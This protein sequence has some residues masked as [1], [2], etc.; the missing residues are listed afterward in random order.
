MDIQL[1]PDEQEQIDSV[2]LSFIERSE[3]QG[4]ELQQL[5]FDA[6]QI[7]GNTE[8]RWNKQKEMG[9]IKRFWHKVSGGASRDNA[10]NTDD[11]I[12]VQKFAF[13]FLQILQERQLMLAH[14]MLAVKNNLAELA[15]EQKE[16]KAAI[17]EMAK[18]ISRRFNQLEQ[19][20]E[21][22]EISDSIQTWL[23]TIEEE[24]YLLDFPPR[25]R[26]LTVLKQFYT[27]KN[28][29]WNMGELKMFRSALRRVK[30]DHKETIKLSVFVSE[31]IEELQKKELLECYNDLLYLTDEQDQEIGM[32][33]LM[34]NVSIPGLLALKQLPESFERLQPAIEVLQENLEIE[35]IQAMCKVVDKDIRRTFF[36]DL[37]QQVGLFEL[38]VQ[39]LSGFA[40]SRE[41]SSDMT[42][43]TSMDDPAGTAENSLSKEDEKLLSE[44]LEENDFIDIH[45][46]NDEG[47]SYPLRAAIFEEDCSMARL[48]LK[49]GADPNAAEFEGIEMPPL[50]MILPVGLS[51]RYETKNAT[52]MQTITDMVKLLL[53]YGADPNARAENNATAAFEFEGVEM[54][55]L[56]TIL[57][58][59]LSALNDLDENATVMQAVI[60]RAKLL[61]EYGADPNARAE[62]EEIEM[63][64][65]HMILSLGLV[66]NNEFKATVMQA[67]IDRVKLLLESGADPNTTVEFHGVEMPPLLV[68]LSVGLDLKYALNMIVKQDN[69]YAG[70]N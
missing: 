18:R 12:Q 65:L 13:R 35:P 14:T 30:L 58:A 61:L 60:D 9:G 24:D 44:W 28:M 33:F 11:M 68:I 4:A 52:V 22:L 38:G 55:P 6:T 31:L 48:L 70:N 69:C 2:L 40:L 23:L 32:N 39:L 7:L 5:A 64:P 34:E 10:S 47:S 36:I 41:L 37:D 25:I 56:H 19:R 45:T 51:D 62:F 1:M 15:I 29:D 49:K 16:T 67:T 43:S 20:A 59:G 17:V 54:S 21:K 66:D 26:F 46:P 27:Q 63:S 53:E 8:E 57:S 42:G 3:N 50:H